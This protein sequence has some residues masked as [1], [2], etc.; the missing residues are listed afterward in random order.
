MRDNSASECQS[1][2]SLFSISGLNPDLDVNDISDVE[3]LCRLC[4]LSCEKDPKL[5]MIQIA[6]DNPLSNTPIVDL[7]RDGLDID[8]KKSMPGMPTQV[9]ASCLSQLW[10]FTKFKK[11]SLG[12]DAKLQHLVSRKIKLAEARALYGSALVDGERPSSPAPLDFNTVEP[13]I[14]EQ[15]QQTVEDN[16]LNIEQSSLVICHESDELGPKSSELQVQG[17]K[18]DFVCSSPF[19]DNIDHPTMQGNIVDSKLTVEVPSQKAQAELTQCMYNPQES[20]NTVPKILLISTDVS[21]LIEHN[22]T[23]SGLANSDKI[24]T[25][26]ESISQFTFKSTKSPQVLDT[27]ST[28]PVPVQKTT[29]TEVVKQPSLPCNICDKTFSSVSQLKKHE[30]SHSKCNGVV[31]TVCN[32]WFKGKNALTRHERIHSGEKPFKCIL[33]DRDFTQKEILQRHILTHTDDKPF[34]CNDCN[35]SYTQKEGL[36]NHVKQ[37]HQTIYEIRQYPCLLCEKAFCHPSGLSRH[38]MIHSGKQFSC[39]ICKRTFTDVSSFRRHKKTQHVSSVQN[40]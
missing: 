24:D 16:L 9:C 25:L 31:C 15:T 6:G 23:I 4:M 10:T 3:H 14:S 39:D 19:Q 2:G 8:I 32:K 38:M 11:K 34:A 22:A 28:C 37:H 35:K 29:T 36:A 30:A 17:S 1:L 33:C 21:R 20:V 18:T 40:K 12:V 26:S 7:F 5:V 13:D 27:S